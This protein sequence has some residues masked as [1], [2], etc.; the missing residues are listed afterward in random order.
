MFPWW[1]ALIWPFVGIAG[2]V[3]HI[4]VA[5]TA[6]TTLRKL[7]I[8]LLWW[9]AF[10]VGVTALA[11]FMSIIIAPGGIADQIGYNTSPFEFEVGSSNLAFAAL[12][13][14]CLRFRGQFWEATTIGVTI[15]LW[16]AAVGHIYQYAVNGNTRPYNIGAVLYTD[17]F[18]QVVLI[19]ALVLFRR[20]QHVA[21]RDV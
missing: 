6:N 15:F 2:A 8:F 10:G 1:G 13:F 3:I 16:G 17:I 18:V 12:G 11:A 20:Q 5:K 19:I 14:L 21:R 9:F 7:E 4:A